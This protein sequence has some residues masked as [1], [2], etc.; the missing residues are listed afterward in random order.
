MR[1][2]FDLYH[3]FIRYIA[4][5]KFDS[6]YAKD[7]LRHLDGSNNDA[8]YG[9]YHTS[10]GGYAVSGFTESYTHGNKDISLY[11]LDRTGTR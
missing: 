6:S 2:Y 1:L 7:W 8:G 9:L 10:N 5:W 3:Q 11:R 4:L